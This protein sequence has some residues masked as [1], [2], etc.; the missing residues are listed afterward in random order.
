MDSH[1][2]PIEPYNSKQLVYDCGWYKTVDLRIASRYLPDYPEEDGSLVLPWAL[3]RAIGVKRTHA[4]A[5]LWNVP[6]L[7]SKG[8]TNFA[9]D[10]IAKHACIRPRTFKRH[11]A[12][13]KE[14]GAITIERVSRR[15][16]A[17]IRLAPEIRKLFKAGSDENFL[18]LPKIWFSRHAGMNDNNLAT[19]LVLLAYYRFRMGH[20]AGYCVDSFDTITANIGGTATTWKRASS[21]I[22]DIGEVKRAPMKRGNYCVSDPSNRYDFPNSRQEREDIGQAILAVWRESH[23]ERFGTEPTTG[24]VLDAWSI[25]ETSRRQLDFALSYVREVVC[26]SEGR[27]TFRDVV[28]RLGREFSALAPEGS[29]IKATIESFPEPFAYKPKMK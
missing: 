26:E 4:L 15:S 18:L 27:L 9:Q 22:A 3:L 19:P 5:A 17:K 25:Y 24:S 10:N 12:E 6:E 2:I 1:I 14:A 11:L 23:F 28:N 16:P 29:T 21:L 13:L 7:R 20:K 8:S